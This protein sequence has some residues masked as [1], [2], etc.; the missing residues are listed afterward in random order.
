MW[1]LRTQCDF[2]FPGPYGDGAG[3]DE[4]SNGN[5]QV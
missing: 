1:E 2:G 4:D 5:P 3:S